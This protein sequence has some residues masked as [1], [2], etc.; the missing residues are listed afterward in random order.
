MAL[1]LIDFH[2][3]MGDLLYLLDL[4]HIL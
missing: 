4:D 2:I 1:V 3:K